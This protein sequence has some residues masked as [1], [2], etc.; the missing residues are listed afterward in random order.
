[1]LETGCSDLFSLEGVVALVTGASS[2]LGEHFARVLAHEGAK[3]VVAARRSRQLENL[4][5]ELHSQG[6]QAMAVPLDVTVES[7]VPAALDAIEECFGPVT[8]LINNAGVAQ[9]R[10]CLKVDG[11]NWDRIMGTNLK[12]AWCV[13]RMVAERCVTKSLSGSIVN[14]AS[15]L[16]IRQGFGDSTYGV[17][18]AALIQLTKSM[19]LE[20]ANKGVRVNA[21]CPG[22][23]AT[24]MNNEFL[25]SSKGRKMLANSVPGRAG[26]MR[27]LDGPLL[28]LASG[29]GSFMSGVVLPVD[30]GHL[31]GS[32]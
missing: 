20:L 30:G 9:S 7:S 22:Y 6:F 29:A 12:G 28:L 17:S 24:E 16:G 15:I 27:E 11:E 14:I 26:R 18:K 19:A 21:L 23:F 1:M 3:V 25:S 4:V 31:V 10:H 32:L 5:H 2:G 13:A 8:L